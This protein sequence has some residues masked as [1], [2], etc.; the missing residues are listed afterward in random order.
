MADETGSTGSAY[1]A[2]LK[3]IARRELSEVQVRQRLARKGFGEDQVDEANARLREERAIDDRR[4]AEAIA[5]TESG[6]KGRGRLRVRR[7]IESAGISRETARQTVD[8]VLPAE[9]DEARLEAAL[10]RRLRGR[11]MPGED[12][13]RAKLY[14]YLIGQGFDSD[15]V[16]RAIRKR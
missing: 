7:K 6:L 1:L 5:R 9:D 11:T 2:G 13:E 8:D 4:V 14:R 12:A 15:R 10:T 16:M 3:M